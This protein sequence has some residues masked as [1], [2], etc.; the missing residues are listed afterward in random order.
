LINAN[1]AAMATPA[2]P[3]DITPAL[4]HGEICGIPKKDDTEYGTDS[5]AIEIE[6]TNRRLRFNKITS[7]F[8]LL[9]ILVSSRITHDG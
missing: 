4:T 9:G 7:S 5:T 8:F 3:A 2:Q 6:K 1:F